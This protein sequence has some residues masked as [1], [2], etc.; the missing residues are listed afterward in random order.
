MDGFE[1]Q[2]GMRAYTQWG[3]AHP[4]HITGTA[5]SGKVPDDC[6]C[7]DCTEK[8]KESGCRLC[9]GNK[10]LPIFDPN[11]QKVS[12]ELPCPYCATEKEE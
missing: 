8:R 7:D 11:E 1:A 6:D 9:E 10:V 4:W 2:E 12:G 3:L 5:E